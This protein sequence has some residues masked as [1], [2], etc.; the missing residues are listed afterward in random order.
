MWNTDVWDLR[1]LSGLAK[2]KTLVLMSTCVHDLIPLAGMSELESLYLNFSRISDLK[3]LMGL[4]SLKALGL[5]GTGV[6]DLSP[7]FALEQ[8]EFIDLSGCRLRAIPHYVYER[9]GTKQLGLEGTTLSTQPISIFREGDEAIRAYYDA[10]KVPVREAKVIFLGD[11]GA[12]KTHTIRR[13][14]QKGSDDGIDTDVTLGISIDRYDVED[15]G[16]HI[17]FW[18]FGGQENMHAMHRCFLTERTLYVVVLNSRWDLDDQARRWLDNIRAFAP[19]SPVILAVNLWE[20]VH[21]YAMDT[22]RILRDYPNVFIHAYAAKGV[23]RGGFRA[24]TALIEEKAEALDSCSMELPEDWA[25]VLE[26]LREKGKQKPVPGEKYKGYIDKSEYLKICGQHGL[27]GE[28]NESIR[29]W[30]LEW[31]ND[32]GVCFSYHRDQQTRRELD[33]YKVLEP[34][35]LT[36]AIYY[37]INQKESIGDNGHVDHYTIRN[38]LKYADPEELRE[39]GDR[40]YILPDV[41]YQ[42]EECGYILQVMRKFG[43]S[44]E[45]EGK[46]Q[47][48]IPALCSG[49]TPDGLRPAAW[50]DCVSYEFRYRFLPD[51]VVQRLMVRLRKNWQFTKLWR[52]GFR[53]DDPHNGLITVADAGGG[54]DSLRLDVYSNKE[55]RGWDVM[56]SLISRITAI[57]AELNLKPEEY[58][59][60]RGD[61]GEIAAPADMILQAKQKGVRSLHLYS[62]E[63]GLVERDVNEIL[64]RTYSPGIIS[65]AAAVAEADHRSLSE[66]VS[67]VIHNHN[68]YGDIISNAA[69]GLLFGLLGKMVEQNIRINDRFVEHYLRQLEGSDDPEDKKVVEEARKEGKGGLLNLLK[70]IPKLAAGAKSTLEDSKAAAAIIKAALLAYGPQVIEGL[71]ELLP[72]GLGG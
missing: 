40:G 58:I 34:R 36:G 46:A 48:F 56:L 47:E 41:R 13:I 59:I 52:R 70:G 60:V 17:N 19:D 35:W 69:P 50:N 45:I 23:D 32:L 44:F 68:I 57:N 65:T 66:T 16:F 9:C 24:L 12:G 1:P 30:L 27:G 71:Q 55:N 2:L 4:V 26:E 64:G 38:L 18:D 51:S 15:K 53:Y 49:E 39:G 7:L 10:G 37:L 42:P 62:R 29:S 72:P 25:A 61:R 8:L 28:K 54:R 22:G 31:F 11:G 33:A 21:R 3:P 14:L 6:S 67:G 63:N 20:G 43:L 5:S